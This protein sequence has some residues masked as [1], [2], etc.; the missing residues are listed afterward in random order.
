M[1]ADSPT[2]VQLQYLR[3]VAGGTIRVFDLT[4]WR[5]NGN[6]SR[7]SFVSDSD[8]LDGQIACV[9]PALHLQTAVRCEARG[10]TDVV[11]GGLIVLT[12]AGRGLLGAPKVDP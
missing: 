6:V 7:R 3:R 11:E 5:R 1:G 2:A 4:T 9:G 12:P 10:W 8:V